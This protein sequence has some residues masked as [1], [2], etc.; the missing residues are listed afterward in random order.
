[1]IE[2]RPV[3]AHE[4]AEAA[5]VTVAAYRAL[6]GA[7]MEGG[8]EDELRDI[9]GRHRDAEVLVAAEAGRILGTVTYIAD[10]AS[11]WA[12]AQRPDEAGIR[13]LGVA[14]EAQGRGVGQ[15]LTEA[16]V[17]RAQ[18][19]GCAAISL[20]TTEWMA[21]AHRIYERLGFER[22]PDRDWDTPWGFW[23]RCY[24]RTLSLTR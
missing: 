2:V 20:F 4:M 6:P 22:A 1:M 8:Y 19:Q 23:L 17:A 15:A 3:A 18:A 11:P 9:A 16:C 21:T 14:P 10:P 24:V 7:H 12:D 13:M 5:E